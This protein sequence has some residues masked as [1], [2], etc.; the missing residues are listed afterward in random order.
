M[1]KTTVATLKS[2]VKK[3]QANLLIKVESSFDGMTDS[4]ERVNMPFKPIVKSTIDCS[5][6]LGINGV[7]LVGSSRDSVRPI[8][9][10]GVRGFEVYNSCGSFKIG[11]AA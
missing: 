5:N 4:V 1:T 7:W 8:E 3:N 11:V 2:F 6:N 9:E 10:N